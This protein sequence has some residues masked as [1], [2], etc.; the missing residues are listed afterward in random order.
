[1]LWLLAR[2][3]RSVEELAME[4]CTPRHSSRSGTGTKPPGTKL[5]RKMPRLLRLKVILLMLILVLLSLVHLRQLVLSPLLHLMHLVLFSLGHW[6]LVRQM[7]LGL[8]PHLRHLLLIPLLHLRILLLFS[9]AHV[10]RQDVELLMTSA[11]GTTSR[12]LL[13]SPLL[14]PRHLMTRLPLLRLLLHLMVSNLL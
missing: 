8:L 6:S 4:S 13:L 10:K 2:H 1:M 7:L 3:Q 14:H 5:N 11:G 12:P 9:L